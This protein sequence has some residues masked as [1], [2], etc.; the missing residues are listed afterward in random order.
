M[1]IIQGIKRINPLDLNKNIKIGMAFPLNETNFFNGTENT[2]DQIKSNLLNLLFTYPGERINLPLF[3]VGLKKLVFEQ[4]INLENLKK[5]IQIQINRYIPNIRLE[6][7][8]A[9]NSEDRHTVTISLT[10]LYLLDNSQ[11]T[12]QLNFNY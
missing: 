5:T 8:K 11:D 3:G 2:K 7:I 10:Y 12:I 9:T 6:N 4:K 1:P